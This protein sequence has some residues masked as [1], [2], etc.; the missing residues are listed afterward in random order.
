MKKM[1]FILLD[2]SA[3]K[4]GLYT[5]P[6][7]L[8][9]HKVLSHLPGKLFMDLSENYVENWILTHGCLIWVRISHASG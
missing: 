3:N 7:D 4:A 6:F 2:Y 1:W 5:Y 8:L 9:H